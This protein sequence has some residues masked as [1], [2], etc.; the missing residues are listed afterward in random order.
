MGI[1]CWQCE[2]SL[3]SKVTI[4]LIH[5]FDDEPGCPTPF[6]KKCADKIKNGTKKMRRI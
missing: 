4:Y 2:K 6:C 1:I 3:L 5:S